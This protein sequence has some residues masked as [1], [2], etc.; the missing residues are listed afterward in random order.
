MTIFLKMK[1]IVILSVLKTNILH[2]FSKKQKYYLG[3][4]MLP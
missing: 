4:Y 2:L 1:N 3:K